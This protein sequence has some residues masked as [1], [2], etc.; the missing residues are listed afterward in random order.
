MHKT[1]KCFHDLKVHKSCAARSRFELSINDIFL[2]KDYYGITFPAPATL[3]GRDG[4]LADNPYSGDVPRFGRGDSASPA[5]ATTLAQ[6]QQNQTQTH[7]TTQQPFLNPTLPPGYSYT[8]LPYYAGVPGVPSA[9]QYGPT[10]FVPPASAKQHGVNLSTAST[11]FQQASSY[12]QHGYGAAWGGNL[13]RFS[14]GKCQVLSLGRSGPMHQCMPGAR[15]AGQ[16]PLAPVRFLSSLK[17]FLER[18]ES[19][20]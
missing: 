4:S 17:M 1:K 6:P 8:G 2:S 19:S 14:E 3:T 13:M 10:M 5:P 20:A 7:H 15:A 16:T 12:G 11:P 18:T 9:F